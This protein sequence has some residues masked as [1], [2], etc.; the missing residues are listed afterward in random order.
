MIEKIP[1][2]D[3]SK[4]V[5]ALDLNLDQLPIERALGVQWTVESDKLGFRIIINDKPLTCRGVLSTISSIYDPLG[6]VA[7]VLLPG[8]RI[9]QDLCREKLNWDDE[10]SDEYHS[11][12]EQW[13]ADLPALEQFSVMSKTRQFWKGRCSRSPQLL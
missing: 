9:L 3:R 11:R 1:E 7:P 4:E 2:D 10:L 12:W 13:K 5:K 6:M 8:K